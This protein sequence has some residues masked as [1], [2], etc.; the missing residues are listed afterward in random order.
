LYNPLKILE[1]DTFY[2]NYLNLSKENENDWIVFADKVKEIMLKAKTD[3]LKTSN[4]GCK[5]ILEFIEILKAKNSNSKTE[6]KED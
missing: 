3:H 6:E 4:S 2:P 5:D 1:L